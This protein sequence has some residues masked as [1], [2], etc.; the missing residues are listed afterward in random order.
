MS[1]YATLKMAEYSKGYSATIYS[2][3]RDNMYSKYEIIEDTQVYPIQYIV[4]NYG[5]PY[6]EGVVKGRY[7]T[8]S[9]ALKRIAEL[10]NFSVVN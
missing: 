9:N 4:V 2:S 8:K 1:E 7:F 5:L 3:Q 10:K 6:G